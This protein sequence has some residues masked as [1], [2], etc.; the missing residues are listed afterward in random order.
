MAFG[1]CEAVSGRAVIMLDDLHSSFRPVLDH[2][3]TEELLS[4]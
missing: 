2:P 4:P 3:P 1:K